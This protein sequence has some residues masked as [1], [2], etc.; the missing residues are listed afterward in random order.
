MQAVLDIMCDA[1]Q[2]YWFTHQDVHNCIKEHYLQGKSWDSFVQYLDG[3][4]K[5]KRK[6]KLIDGTYFT[7]QLTTY[8]VSHDFMDA[9]FRILL[10]KIDPPVMNFDGEEDM[11]DCFK[12]EY[13]G[14]Y[15]LDTINDAVKTYA[16]RSMVKT[17]D[18]LNKASKSY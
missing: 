3:V 1:K 4:W 5:E 2:I 8:H 13:L 15:N 6:L 12:T 14:V 11:P 10:K 7:K 16:L 18:E 17:Y 9:N